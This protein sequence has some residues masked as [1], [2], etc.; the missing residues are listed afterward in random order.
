MAVEGSAVRNCLYN[1]CRTTRT[2]GP[3]KYLGVGCLITLLCCACGDPDGSARGGPSG[4]A[5]RTG[6]IVLGDSAPFDPR[7]LK[8]RPCPA[9]Q[10]K[11]QAKALEAVCLENLPIDALL[12]FKNSDGNACYCAC[13]RL[14]K[15]HP[16]QR[17][18]LHARLLSY[19]NL[20]F[21]K[22]AGNMAM[23][24]PPLRKVVGPVTPDT[25]NRMLQ[26]TLAASSCN[27]KR[28][29]LPFQDGCIKLDRMLE[30]FQEAWPVFSFAFIDDTTYWPRS[31]PTGADGAGDVPVV[32]IS[33]PENF[34]REREVKGELFAFMIA[35]E[36]SHGLARGF[37]CSDGSTLVC[38]GQCDWWAANRIMREVFHDASYVAVMTSAAEQMAAYHDEL[39]GDS[40]ECGEAL[41]DCSNPSCGYPPK[42]CR[43]KS[44]EHALVAP[45]ARPA[46][47]KGWQRSFP[48]ECAEWSACP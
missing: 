48:A 20:L 35:H 1:V 40:A 21:R 10:C 14:A 37:T 29:S 42:S 46:C 43:V 31:T 9:E 22:R 25:V 5:D 3:A 34:V 12:W 4:P 17:D 26:R 8:R 44:I 18:T 6:T 39:Y 24:R 38:E 16:S 23:T 13:E 45:P 2:M 41:C 36:I 27:R 19:E 32:H 15:L 30:R 11:G 28:H 33:I 47:V 7:Y